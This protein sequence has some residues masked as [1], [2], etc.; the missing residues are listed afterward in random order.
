MGEQHPSLDDPNAF[1]LY[2]YHPN[3]V[4]A[5]IFVVLFAL[6]T[7]LHIFQSF[8]RKAWFLIPLIIGGLC[9]FG[10]R[11]L[12]PAISR[13]GLYQTDLYRCRTVETVGYV[14]RA[15]SAKNQWAL[16]PYIIQSILLLVAPA[17]FAASIYMTLGR[18]IL[19]RDAEQYSIIKKKWLTKVF[20]CGDILSFLMQSGGNKYPGSGGGLSCN[21]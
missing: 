1:V 10:Y 13:T 21:I 4:A 20:V 19:I 2:R 16:G 17:L 7:A 12:L 14:G 5:V 9:E 18:I 3:S 6:S 11:L 8:R 15:Q